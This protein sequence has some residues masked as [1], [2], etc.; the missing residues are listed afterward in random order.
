MAEEKVEKKQQ[1]PRKEFGGKAMES[2]W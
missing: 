2:V 1:V